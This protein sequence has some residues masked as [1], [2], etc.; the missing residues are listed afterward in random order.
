MNSLYSYIYWNPSETIIQIGSFAPR[1][2]GLFWMVGLLLGAAFMFR[3]YKAQG[4]KEDEA[5]RLFIYVFLS[6]FIGARLGHCIFYEANYYFSSFSH[7]LEIVLPIRFSEDGSWKYIG[8][9]GLASHGG[10]IGLIIGLAFYHR[11]TKIPM[12]VVLDNMGLCACITAAFIRLGNLMNSEIIGK[13]TD[14]PWAFIFEKVDSLPRH[15]GQLYEAIFYLIFF[16]IIY[17]VYLKN[18]ER[19]GSGL[20][21][22]L[23]LSLVFTLRFFIE[24]TKEVQ[25]PFENNMYLNMGQV[26][27]IPFILIGLYFAFIR[28]K[29]R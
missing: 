6:V 4:I 8:Y 16:L 23:C 9:Q 17:L 10:V 13:P 29:P 7:F 15:P 3:L 1:W 11:K 5:Q 12:L 28:R 14:A 20:F 22:G 21:F 24:F 2:Y 18:K 26:L 19:V 27:S 25:V